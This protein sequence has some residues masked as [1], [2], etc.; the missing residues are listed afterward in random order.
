MIRCIFL[1]APLLAAGCAQ[2][3]ATIDWL[4]SDRTRQAASNL[5]TLAAAFDCGI[6]VSGAALSRSIAAAV[7][8]G[9]A[10]V[11]NAGKVYAVSAAIC[12]ELRDAP[13][14]GA[15]PTTR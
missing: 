5:R 11:A 9:D 10:A 12:A 14:A 1:L 8:A 6:V 7:E 3:E 2:V 13:S 15:G 4:A